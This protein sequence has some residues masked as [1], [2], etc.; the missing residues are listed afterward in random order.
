MNVKHS[1]TEI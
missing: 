1:G